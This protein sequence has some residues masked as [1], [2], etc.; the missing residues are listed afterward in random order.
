[1]TVSFCLFLHQGMKEQAIC[2]WR[3]VLKMDPAHAEARK[4][5]RESGFAET[6]V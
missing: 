1:M 5:L 3:L 2:E 4:N 6:G